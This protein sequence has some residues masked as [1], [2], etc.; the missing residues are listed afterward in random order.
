MQRVLYTGVRT[1]ISVLEIDVTDKDLILPIIRL[2]GD[3]EDAYIPVH[4]HVLV[5]PDHELSCSYWCWCSV[6]GDLIIPADSLST[7]LVGYR[8]VC[9]L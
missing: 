8:V 4:V 7:S 5:K 9:H 6:L 1:R 2:E 3:Q